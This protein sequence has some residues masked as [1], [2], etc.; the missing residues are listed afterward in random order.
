[1][2]LREEMAAQADNCFTWYSVGCD[3]CGVFPITGRRYKCKECTELIGYDLCGACYDRGTAS[4]GRFNQAHRPEHRMVKMEPCLGRSAA[5]A[6]RR[7]G[8][9]GGGPEAATSPEGAGRDGA[10]SV[11]EETAD[12]GVQLVTLMNCLEVLHPELS[13]EQATALVMMH[14]GGGVTL[15]LLEG[16]TNGA[17]GGGGGGRSGGTTR[18]NRNGPG[19]NGGA[20]GSGRQNGTGSRGRWAHLL[21]NSEGRGGNVAAAAGPRFGS[22]SASARNS[23]NNSNNNNR[24]V[25]SWTSWMS[26]RGNG[27]LTQ[28]QNAFTGAADVVRS[29]SASRDGQEQRALPGSQSGSQPARSGWSQRAGAG[30]C[31]Q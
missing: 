3:D 6:R 20:D 30:C 4:R 22:E 5:A 1:M 25:W 29:D 12:Q 10:P 15:D 18:V 23:N 7:R 24:G 28:R 19:G 27:G 16:S 26:R 2:A 14:L 13:V 11:Q 17:G 21:D 8:G 9:G 31:V